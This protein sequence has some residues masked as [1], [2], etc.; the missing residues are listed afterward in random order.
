[1]EDLQV[2]IARLSKKIMLSTINTLSISICEIEAQSS[3]K[4]TKRA[5]HLCTLPEK[6]W[7]SYLYL[8]WLI[9]HTMR[10]ICQVHEEGEEACS[11]SKCS[12]ENF[13]GGKSTVH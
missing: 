8:R 1:V 2:A 9:V 6:I 5:G 4:R 13:L 10:I 12:A 7:K 11:M 3:T